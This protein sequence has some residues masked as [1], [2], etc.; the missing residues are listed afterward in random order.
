MG[1]TSGCADLLTKGATGGHLFFTTDDCR[2]TYEELQAKGVEF[3]QEPTEQPY[4]IDAVCATRSAIT[5]AFRSQSRSRLRWQAR[6]PGQRRAARTSFPSVN[7]CTF[8]S[9]VTIS[10]SRTADAGA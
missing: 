7:D 10:R 3:T 4:G 8:P 9:A 1:P 6:E 5:S 2:K